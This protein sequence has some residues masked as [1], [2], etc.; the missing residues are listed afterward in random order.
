MAEPLKNSFGPDVVLTVADMVTSV[1]PPFDRARYLAVALD[2][3]DELE[4][5]ARA[6]QVSDALAAVLP[7][8]RGQALE[9]VAAALDFP[10]AGG[11]PT[12]MASFVYMPFGVFIAEH[13]LD[14]F[15]LA[16]QAQ[17]ELTQRFTAEFSIRP[18][19]ERYPEE[20]LSRLATW[21]THP[22][23]HV[24]RLVSEGTRPRLPWA[25]RLRAFQEDPGPVLGLLERLKDDD[26]E[27]VRRSVANNLNDIA[28]DHPE[29]VVEVARRWWS[30]EDAQR[31]ALVR[32]ALRTLVKQGHPEALAVL[33]F[34]VDSPARVKELRC[35]PASAAIGDSVRIEIV[36]DNPSN[37]TIPVR[38][39]FRV[40][41]VKSG[42]T[43]S[44]K[45]F[46]GAVLEIEPGAAV[47]VRKTVSVRQ[48][49]TRKHYPGR[50]RVDV[51][52]N[53]VVHEEGDEWGFVIG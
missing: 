10:F 11:R 40:H 44:P 23:H 31:R 51:L 19:L 4:L 35:T 26:S 13:G 25:G 50:H 21:C 15:E 37:R 32:H 3:F 45:V 30:D 6:K 1:Y 48:H 39:D 17:L 5:T 33:G 43:T 12:G 8:A 7:A 27:Y 20:T 42:G 28:K 53:G 29:T 36:V 41:F 38:V 14:H 16:M 49:T 24:R 22:N 46:K 18:F 34:A 2:G 9:I 52:L 47:V